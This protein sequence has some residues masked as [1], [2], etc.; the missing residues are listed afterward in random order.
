MQEDRP[1]TSYRIRT[2]LIG[3]QTTVLVLVLLGPIVVLSSARDIPTAQVVGLCILTLIGATITLK[4][5][6]QRFF[7]EG[8]A[9]AWLYTWSIADIAVITVFLA[10]AGPDRPGYFFL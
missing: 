9:F 7:A 1:L 2:V 5:P 6:W 10:L 4:L 3:F 8:T